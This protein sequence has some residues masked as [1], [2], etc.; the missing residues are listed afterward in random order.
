MT[1]GPFML[2]GYDFKRFGFELELEPY[3]IRI[4][5]KIKKLASLLFQVV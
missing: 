5:C 1:N 2:S 4:L 3:F